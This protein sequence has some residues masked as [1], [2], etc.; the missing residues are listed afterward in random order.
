MVLDCSIDRRSSSTVSNEGVFFIMIRFNIKITGSE[1][2]KE[3]GIL[4]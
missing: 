3:R 4:I 2:D 1:I